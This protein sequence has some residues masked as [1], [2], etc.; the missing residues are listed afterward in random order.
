VTLRGPGFVQSY[1]M[2][3]KFRKIEVLILE[4]LLVLNSFGVVCV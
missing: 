1:D 2:N 3:T 4:R